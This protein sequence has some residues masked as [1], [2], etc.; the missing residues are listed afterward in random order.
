MDLT[1]VFSS[2]RAFVI[3]DDTI[4][5]DAVFGVL[6]KLPIGLCR[7]L[8]GECPS[9]HRSLPDES[10]LL[11]SLGE[12][13]RNPTAFRFSE[14]TAIEGLNSRL[15]CVALILFNYLLL[16]PIRPSVTAEIDHFA[17]PHTT[18]KY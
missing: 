7:V 11:G 18:Q 10:K 16:G 13:E 1:S 15:R 5:G 14:G 4:C 8:V 17:F 9:E 6:T 12:H 2:A 3:S